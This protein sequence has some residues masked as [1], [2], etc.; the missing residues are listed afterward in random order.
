MSSSQVDGKTLGRASV[1][2]AQD[3]DGV[4]ALVVAHPGHELRV[5]SW[6]ECARPRVSV[7]TDGSGHADQARL[8]STAGVL[9]RAGASRGSIFGRLSDRDAYQLILDGSLDEV[10]ALVLELASQLEE[11]QVDLVVSDAMEGFNPVH[12]LCFVIA[13]GAVRLVTRRLGRP[14]RHYDFLLEAAPDAQ[15]GL[16]SGQ[17]VRHELD[18]SAWRRK[19]EA[20]WA[21]GK[22][23]LE[24]ERAID[25]HGSSA[26]RVEVLRTV[27]SSREI[28]DRISEPPFYE[29]HGE[30]RVADGVYNQVLRFREH[31]L[32][33]ANGIR[34]WTA[35][36]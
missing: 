9:D 20:A 30:Q 3:E 23:R 35:L 10:K 18:E 26:F 14:V 7:L 2:Q 22:L 1:V 11:A 34:A 28:S 17:I 31:F 5:H 27:D 6:L 36:T 25:A 16:I 32:P 8:G 33:L 19:M 24:V 13:E 4:A 15:T 21:Y 29:T 12:D